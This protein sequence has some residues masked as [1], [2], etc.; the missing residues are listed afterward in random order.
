VFFRVDMVAR[1]RLVCQYSKIDP[2]F[3]VL[4]LLG[5]NSQQDLGNLDAVALHFA[6]YNFT[7]LYDSRRG[8]ELAQGDIRGRSI[9]C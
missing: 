8:F 1:S 5:R 4:L 7:K 9:G 2:S 3:A 6:Y